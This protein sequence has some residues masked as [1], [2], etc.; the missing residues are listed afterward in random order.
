MMSRC[1]VGLSLED[2]L[3][4]FVHC[5]FFNDLRDEYPKLLISDT[6]RVLSGSSLPASAL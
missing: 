2:P 3:H 1:L 4:R 6:R 5:P